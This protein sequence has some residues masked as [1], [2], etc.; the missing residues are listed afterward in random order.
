[1]TGELHA[2]IDE[3]I[4]A[5]G[6]TPGFYLLAAAIS[7]PTSAESIR[8]S[9]RRLVPRPRRRLH[10]NSEDHRTR[11]EIVDVIA[12]TSLTHVIVLA[13][14]EA[15]RQERARR[16]C[17]QRLLFE[18]DQRGVTRA[19]IESRQAAQDRRD[20][21]M[22]ASLHGS[23]AISPGFTVTFAK[24]LDDPMLWIPDAVAGMTLAALRDDNH[25]WLDQLNGAYE[26]IRL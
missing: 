24:P 18:L 16:K 6:P 3:S 13:E 19:W 10:W 2:W 21:E 26:L 22:V 15:R 5:Q 20:Q 4:H 7:D 23:G 17:L 11:Y 25:A 9:L 8:E 1:M 12:S 14:V